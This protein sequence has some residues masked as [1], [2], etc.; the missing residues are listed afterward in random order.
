MS[1]VYFWFVN[2]YEEKKKLKLNIREIGGFF[3]YENMYDLTI[4][5]S[6]FPPILFLDAVKIKMAKSF[7]KNVKNLFQNS[8]KQNISLL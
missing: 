4:Y 1:A 8:F 2:K 7:Q 6:F 3:S 5:Y